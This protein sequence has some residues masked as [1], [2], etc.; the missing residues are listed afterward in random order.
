[1]KTTVFAFHPD[2]ANGSRINASLA[3][4]ASEAGFEVRDVYSLYPDFKIDVAAEQAALEAS[5]RIVLQFPIY[6]YQTPALLKQWFDAVLE[7]GWAYGST[8]NALRGKEVILAASFGAA[9]DDYQLEGRFHTTVEEVLKPIATIQ[10][11][12]GLLFLEPF[13]TTGTLNLSDEALNEQAKEYLNVL[14]AE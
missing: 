11:H 10:Y 14:S 13:I 12:T 9:L 4:A 1:M 2:L 8:G 6:W 5:D 3:K 7:Y